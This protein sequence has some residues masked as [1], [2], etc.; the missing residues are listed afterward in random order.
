MKPLLSDTDQ[1]RLKIRF[2]N[3]AMGVE[4]GFEDL[5]KT[6]ITR[7]GEQLIDFLGFLADLPTVLIG[8]GLRRS[9]SFM[10]HPFGCFSSGTAVDFDL[11]YDF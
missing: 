6:F 3:L 10:S 4:F 7:F 5:F 11:V 1:Q 9:A 8:D 2:D